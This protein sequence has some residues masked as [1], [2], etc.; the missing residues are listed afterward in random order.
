MKNLFNNISNEE[1]NR[2]LEMHSAKK[3]V[4]SEQNIKKVAEGTIINLYID[5]NESQQP[6]IHDEIEDITMNGNVGLTLH[7][8]QNPTVTFECGKSWLMLGKDG[9]VPD[10]TDEKNKRFNK[11]LVKALTNQFCQ[12]NKQGVK[13]PKAD[14][15]MNNQQT[16]TATGI[17]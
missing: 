13:V 11:K 12:S 5:P 2:I 10:D 17:A 16:N 1:K 9:Q 3:N 14:F 15:A 4:I 7:L 6:V 8:S